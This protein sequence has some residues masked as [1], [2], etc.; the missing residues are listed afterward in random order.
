MASPLSLSVQ[1]PML[2][3]RIPLLPRNTAVTAFFDTGF[4]STGVANETAD[5]GLGGVDDFG[6]PLS[7]S[8]Q[9]LQHLAGNK[10]GVLDD[11]VTRVRA[12]DFQEEFAINFKPP[13]LATS[14][15]TPA[16]GIKPQPQDTK[17]C[18]L[19]AATNAFLPTPQSAMAELNNPNTLKMAAE[20]N[21]SFKIPSL[22]NVELTGPYMHN[23]SMATLE[24]V[25]EFYTRGGN[26]T[27]DAK[28]V[29]RVFSLPK[30]ALSEQNR[31]DLVEFLKTL[32]D[33]RVRYE[34][35]PFDHPEILIPHGHEGDQV[36]VTPHALY[37]NLAKDEFLLIPAVGATGTEVPLQPFKHYLAK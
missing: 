10:K 34:K 16:E 1:Q 3:D 7:F 35:A 26:F 5:I 15:F 13:Q 21:A 2:L 36:S 29:T 31:Q 37:P 24:Q 4:A 17:K 14:L 27:N 25:V 12:C 8:K 11:D 19:A 18:F 30:L 6:N 33:D 22:R 32:T 9:Y 28:Q 23:G 20:V